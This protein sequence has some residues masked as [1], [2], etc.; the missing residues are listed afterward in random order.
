[1]HRALLKVRLSLPP[2]A[3]AR[4]EALRDAFIES[5]NFVSEIA[6]EKG[7]LNRVA[8]HHLS[9]RLLRERFPRMGS[10]LACN[11]ILVVSSIHAAYAS[12]RQQKKVDIK[13]IRFLKNTPVVFDR[14]TISLKGQILS[15]YTLDGRMK[16][17]INTN[18]AIEKML[19]NEKLKSVKMF[20]DEEGFY[21][22]FDFSTGLIFQKSLHSLSFIEEIELNKK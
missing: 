20:Q 1:M 9:Y 6:S 21:L 13:R 10:Q 17:K 8:L 11:T 5:C 18:D 14:H 19:I 3:V 16:C 2:N 15:I 12:D 22:N 4:L 7:C